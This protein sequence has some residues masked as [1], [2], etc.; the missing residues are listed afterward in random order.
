MFKKTK[1]SFSVLIVLA[2]VL[3]MFAGIAA[4]A[5]VAPYTV[6]S[7]GFTTV[8][9]GN[10]KAAGTLSVAERL[11]GNWNNDIY[12]SLKLPE[13]VTFNATPT[14]GTLS[15]YVTVTGTVYLEEASS[16]SLRIKL[17]GP[18]AAQ[19]KFNVADHSALNIASG[20]TGDVKATV[21]VYEILG[22]AVQWIE[23]DTRTIARVAAKDVTV[24]AGA[25]TV[26]QM[27][28]SKPAAKITIQEGTAA[29]L[30]AGEKI[31]L[32]I[33]T[34]GVS[35]TS[36]PV[37]TSPM[38]NAATA[39]L[40]PDTSN[41]QYEFT[42]NNASAVFAGKIEIASLLNLNPSVVSGDIQ[43]R[44]RSLKSDSSL[45]T[46]SVVVATVGTAAVEL[47]DVANNTKTIYAGH[48][49]QELK[50]SAGST[51]FQLK[52]TGGSKIPANKIVVLEL[53][54]ATFDAANPFVVT[55][56][57]TSTG[58]FVGLTDGVTIN[59]YSDNTKAW[60][61]TK[62][63]WDVIELRI[64]QMKV[65]APSDAVAGNITVKVSGTLGASGDVVVGQV[66]KPFT[67]SADIVRLAYPGMDQAGSDILIKEA[68]RE[69]IVIGKLFVELPTGVKFASKPRVR[70]TTGDLVVTS[71]NY[72]LDTD[73]VLW[74]NVTGQSSEASTI[75][76]DQITYDVARAAFEGNVTIKVTGET[77][78]NKW[79][80]TK[81]IATGVVARVGKIGRASCRE[82]V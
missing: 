54:G 8:T 22:S 66:A 31:R 4:A 38:V 70:V 2:M 72:G 29:S 15:Q 32:E 24:S 76:I 62:A 48:Q 28:T 19:F 81:V 39:T 78:A 35:F 49:A 5:P 34:S 67:V 42:V 6:F 46:T 53:N 7:S 74:I 41:R 33:V 26:I 68:A 47:V 60:F 37:I 82:R 16:S 18:D 69:A 1:K 20:T 45:S 21:D 12:V 40:V 57:A 44:V 30:D 63:S 13:G 11:T 80:D 43:I 59:L 17:V 79:V 75:T 36:A 56:R 58:N 3:S 55:G 9:T 64:A 23:S 14:T 27:G 65:Y 71:A 77:A 51:R 73:G 25:A 52:A 10:N 50:V 61:E